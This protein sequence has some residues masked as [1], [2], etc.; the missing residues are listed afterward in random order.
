MQNNQCR[1]TRKSTKQW[2]PE[3]AAAAPILQRRITATIWWLH[4]TSTWQLHAAA[5]RQIKVKPEDV[6]AAIAG[7][8]SAA[9]GLGKQ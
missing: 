4:A 2:I 5:A 7:L 1:G 9:E 3:T 8:P 6:L